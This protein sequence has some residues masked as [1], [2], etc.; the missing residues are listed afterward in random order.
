V[1]PPVN[2]SLVPSSATVEAGNR[3]TFD[4]VV[5]GFTDGLRSVDAEANT[6][7]ASAARIT[8]ANVSLGGTLA[9]ASVADDGSGVRIQVIG[10]STAA[11]GLVGTLSPVAGRSTVPRALG[12]S[13]GARRRHRRT[14]VTPPTP[15]TWPS[16]AASNSATAAR[17]GSTESDR[18]PTGTGTGSGS[19]SEAST[20]RASAATPGRAN[21][22]TGR[23]T[24]GS[25]GRPRAS[26]TPFGRR[27]DGLLRRVAEIERDTS[28]TGFTPD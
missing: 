15:F 10:A 25:T 8:D 3:T 16:S 14:A 26:D 12:G 9:D 28:V 4:L 2:V 23:W 17:T 6:T 18:P 7:E 19:G 20:A 5:G 27:R 22:V 1:C 11:T 21:P 13:T 24:P